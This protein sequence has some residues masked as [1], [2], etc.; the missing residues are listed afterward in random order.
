MV[1]LTKDKKIKSMSGH[2]RR[3][4]L[5]NILLTNQKYH[6]T[7]I[8]PWQ[9]FEKKKIKTRPQY[10]VNIKEIKSK[11]KYK[12]TIDFKK[13][14]KV[15]SK[16]KCTFTVLIQ[17]YVCLH[18]FHISLFD[19]LRFLIITHAFNKCYQFDHERLANT[20]SIFFLSCVDNPVSQHCQSLLSC[21]LKWL[22]YATLRLLF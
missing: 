15:D 8:V 7:W 14:K 17:Q 21:C 10:H 22:C 1:F 20:H 3:E 2:R 6:S 12:F 9:V 18:A 19:N 11:T 4:L 16:L 13:Q 5:A